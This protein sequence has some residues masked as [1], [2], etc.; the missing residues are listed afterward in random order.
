MITAHFPYSFELALRILTFLSYFKAPNFV[1]LL[2]VDNVAFITVQNRAFLSMVSAAISLARALY[3][4][5]HTSFFHS[6]FNIAEFM[7]DYYR[8]S[9]FPFQPY[10]SIFILIP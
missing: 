7:C 5:Q 6:H 10:S 8:K 9:R 3:R 4:T 1:W 2:S